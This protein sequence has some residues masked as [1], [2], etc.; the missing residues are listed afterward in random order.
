MSND[1]LLRLGGVTKNYGAVRALEGVSFEVGAG[2]IVALVGDNGAGKSSTVKIVAGAIQPDDGEVWFDGESRRWSSPKEAQAAGIET[3]YQDT[4]LAP[5]LSVAGNIFLGREIRRG[6]VLGRLGFL[7]RDSMQ[8]EAQRHLAELQ[9]R[10]P[11]GEYP[12]AELSGGQ[13]QAVAI[14]KSLTWARKLVLFDEPTNHLGVQ[15]VKQVLELLRRIR[16]AGMGILLVS[17]T[18]PHVLEVSDRIVV[19]WQGQ[20]AA[21][22]DAR[23]TNIDEVV[24]EIT[25]GSAA[26]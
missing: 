2:E 21:T 6:G 12:T 14:A 11:S 18:I 4:G 19:L 9:V 17:H 23:A 13:R 20:V 22:L 16:G 26:A 5:H 15:G 7:D 8:T 10:V 1:A 3:L 25:G 24:K